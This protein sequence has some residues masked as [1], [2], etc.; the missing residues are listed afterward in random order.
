MNKSELDKFINYFEKKNYQVHNFLSLKNKVGDFPSFKSV[1]FP[2]GEVIIKYKGAKQT[3]I[4]NKQ[5]KVL[6]GVNILDLKAMN[7]WHQVFEKDVYWQNAMRHSIIVGH[8][9]TPLEKE[10]DSFL[11]ESFEENNLEHVK[12]DIFLLGNKKKY[13]VFT[14]SEDGQ[15][16]LENFGYKNYEHVDFVG[17]VREEG[18]DPNI[19]KIRS[20]LK[21]RYIKKIWEKYGNM[22]I[23]CGKCTYVCPTCF[24]F[25]IVDKPSLKKGEGERV[26][27]WSSCLFP[28]F[29]EVAGG[30]KFQRNT[31]QRL[32]FWYYHK[33]VRTPEQFNMPGCVG[34]GR[35]SKACPVGIDIRKVIE[36]I[37]KS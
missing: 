10:N 1:L 17:P 20:K 5:K 15:K 21:D 35:C 37:L 13:R 24:C 19:L 12:F 32:F 26:R 4:L 11:I 33:F 23:E 2:S 7:L 31:A 25:D 30:Y 22:C 3:E 27:E 18:I 9:E 14:G 8:L 29:S 34:C 36:D 16:I 6:L 28:N